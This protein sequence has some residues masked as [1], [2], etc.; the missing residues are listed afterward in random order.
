MVCNGSAIAAGVNGAIRSAGRDAR[1][2]WLAA[3]TAIGL[4]LA[5]LR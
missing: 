1:L 2:R 4:L 5:V 3:G